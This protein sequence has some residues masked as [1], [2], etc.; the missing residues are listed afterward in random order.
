MAEGQNQTTVRISDLLLF[1]TSATQDQHQEP[2]S[3]SQGGGWESRL[4]SLVKLIVCDVV[5]SALHTI[6]SP[7]MPIKVIMTKPQGNWSL[8]LVMHDFD[9]VVAVQTVIHSSLYTSFM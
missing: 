3:Q 4:F 8:H 2:N 9:E 5:Y 6:L 1:C 7:Y